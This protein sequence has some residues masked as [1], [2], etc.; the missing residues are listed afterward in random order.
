MDVRGR[1]RFTAARRRELL[2]QYD[3]SGLSGPKFAAVTGL[4]YQTLAAWLQKRR[5]QRDAVA[6]AVTAHKE[7]AVQWLETVVEQAQAP[8]SVL[9]VRLPSGATL[10]VV[11]TAQAPVAAALLRA[12]ESPG[13]RTPC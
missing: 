9:L 8:A 3:Q 4:K 2:E 12:W 11:N 1:M 7:P 13:G 5:M 10:E 6:P